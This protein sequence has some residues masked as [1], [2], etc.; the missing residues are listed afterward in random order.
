MIE[1][2]Y[3]KNTMQFENSVFEDAN[4]EYLK[5]NLKNN[6]IGFLGR[7]NLQFSNEDLLDFNTGLVK[8]YYTYISPKG[9][10]TLLQPLKAD[11]I[12]P[13]VERTSGFGDKVVA[14]N[15]IEYTGQPEQSSLWG[16]MYNVR[17]VGVKYSFIKRGI[18]YAS[19]SK[20]FN[21]L[22]AS[23]LGR[24]KINYGN[25][26]E[27]ALSR[28]MA[29]WKNRCFFFGISSQ[30]S[31][32]PIFGYLNDPNVVKEYV[33]TGANDSKKWNSK[34]SLE[35]SEDINNACRDLNAQMK[36]KLQDLIENN[37]AYLQLT[38]GTNHFTE[39]TKP[40][41]Y[42]DGQPMSMIELLGKTLGKQIK[43]IEVPELDG[44]I[45]NEDAFILELVCPEL[46]SL[47]RLTAIENMYLPTFIQSANTYNEVIMST[48]GQ[49]LRYPEMR[50]V[51]IGI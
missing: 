45:D 10:E 26:L 1:K 6:R 34:T 30:M 41:I 40:N 51:R 25:D 19:I 39:L 47:S 48:G 49:V 20:E 14:I 23:M 27:T 15:R 24:A 29:I 35:I 3:D 33:A 5:D 38:V 13:V 36:G 17:S 16:D 22:K 21:S 32:N 50:V 11:K 2:D 44:N 42:R 18:Y 31:E 43:V 4:L 7:D 28:A 12:A 9:I 37:G 8:Q 46:M